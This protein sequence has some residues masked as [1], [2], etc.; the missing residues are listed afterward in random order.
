MTP[1]I[2]HIWTGTP[3]IQEENGMWPGLAIPGMWGMPSSPLP[4]FSV[5]S[6]IM[7]MT[8][9]VHTSVVRT[10]WDDIWRVFGTPLAREKLLI[11]GGHYELSKWKVRWGDTRR[12][13]TSYAKKIT[14]IQ[15]S[16]GENSEKR[17]GFKSRIDC[18]PTASVWVLHFSCL[19]VFRALWP[20]LQQDS[21]AV[22]KTFRM[23]PHIY[24][25]LQYELV[26]PSSTRN[27][28]QP[29]L[30]PHIGTAIPWHSTCCRSDTAASLQI[31][32]TVPS[33]LG[34]A[35][36]SHYRKERDLCCWPYPFPG[37]PCSAG[38]SLLLG[39]WQ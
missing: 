14:S 11:L 16:R 34:N 21:C 19:L 7:G 28:L 12:E 32:T 30:V 29:E 23:K 15:V 18:L 13:D 10:G 2:S 26:S 22:P 17:P 5:H 3:K 37:W 20:N 25:A 31:R 4:S 39:K 1:Q 36:G 35:L 8:M 6:C 27:C 9:S 24:K 38:S 33:H